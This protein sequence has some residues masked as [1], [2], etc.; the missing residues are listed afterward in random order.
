MLKTIE[1]FDIK[2]EKGQKIGEG[3]TRHDGTAGNVTFESDLT[4]WPKAIAEL[5][6]GAAK[7]EAVKAMAKLGLPDPRVQLVGMAYPVDSDGNQITDPLK[8]QIHRYRIDIPMTRR[9]V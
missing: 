2:D 9:L 6:H 4:D 7:N 3:G 1:E 8:Q 5:T